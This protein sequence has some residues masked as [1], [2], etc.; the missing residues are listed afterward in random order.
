M[1]ELPEGTTPGGGSRWFE[2]Y[3]DLVT[4]LDDAWWDIPS[5]DPVEDR[6]FIFSMAFAAAV[7]EL[8]G[9][10]GNNAEKWSWGDLH[11]LNLVNQSLGSTGIGVIDALFNRGGYQIS[12]GT[13]IVNATGWDA[14][15]EEPYSVRSLPSMRMIVDLDELENSLTIHTTG[16]SGHA[17]HENYVDMTDPWRFIQYKGMLWDRDQVEAE[18]STRLELLP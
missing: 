18:A 1:D 11:T 7:N 6:D 3:A 2:V 12:G 10:L 8:K 16:Q 14:S 17:Y 9:T 13:A 5:T 4:K 15:K